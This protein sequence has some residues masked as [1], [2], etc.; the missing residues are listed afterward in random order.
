MSKD[1]KRIKIDLKEDA[2]VA[3]N[4]ASLDAP[5]G[6]KEPKQQLTSK[7]NDYIK[8]NEREQKKMKLSFKD[9]INV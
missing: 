9:W 5:I 7:T 8:K 3:A 2:T 4:A 6:M 1:S